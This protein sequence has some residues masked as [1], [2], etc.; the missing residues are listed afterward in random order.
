MLE[1]FCFGFFGYG[2][3]RAPHWFM[4]MEEGGGSSSEEI[5]C[6]LRAWSELG[7][8]ELADLEEFHCRARIG[9]KWF[10]DRPRIQMT[11]RGAI[12]ILL[13]YKNGTFPSIEAVRG[14][15]ATEFARRRGETTMMQLLP[16]PSPNARAW[17][18]ARW[19][20]LSWL[21]NRP[22]YRRHL[23]RQRVD[24][25]RCLVSQHRPETVVF[26]GKGCRESWEA[27]AGV[28][29]RFS[30]GKGYGLARRG[31]VKLALA[32]HPAKASNDYLHELG[33]DLREL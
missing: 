22:A 27:I 19:S 18:Y 7:C 8:P 5:K 24:A 3:F 11:W 12:R 23:L 31:K 15:Q 26:F 2:V 28:Q 10:G 29:F 30:S 20:D 1:R 4:G 9:A 32:R 13:S 17:K 14:Y 6:R 33:K 21:A 25:L 16:L